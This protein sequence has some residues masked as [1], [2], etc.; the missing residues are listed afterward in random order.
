MV[1][2]KGVRIKCKEIKVLIHRFIKENQ[3]ST[4][5]ELWK[6]PEPQPRISALNMQAKTNR[7]LLLGE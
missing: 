6:C 2:G 5:G 1:C 3:T 7:I 4:D